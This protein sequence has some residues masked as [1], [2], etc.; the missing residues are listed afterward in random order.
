MRIRHPL[1]LTTFEDDTCPGL[2]GLDVTAIILLEEPPAK[3]HVTF[4]VRNHVLN[5]WPQRIQ[6]VE[7]GVRVVYGQI[8]WVVLAYLLIP[9]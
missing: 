1:R 2:Q 5:T 4:R 9:N 8:E 3:A 6:E 7:C